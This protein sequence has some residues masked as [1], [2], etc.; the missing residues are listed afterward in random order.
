MQQYHLIHITTGGEYRAPLVASQLFDQAE[1]QATNGGN[2]APKSVHAWTIGAMREYRD[3]AAQKKIQEL[4]TRCPHVSIKM[5]NGVSR[6]NA[7]PVLELMRYH[8][9]KMGNEHRAIYHCRGEDAAIWA[10]KLQQY[11]PNDKIVL[12]VRGHWPSEKLYMNGIEYPEQAT[13]EDKNTYEQL[14]QKLRNTVSQVNGVT[15]VS[16]ALR[17]L[18][19]DEAGA[20]QDTIVVPCCVNKITDDRERNKLR[21]DWGVNE[22]V[23]LVVYSGTTAAYQ[24][25]EDLTIPF[26][27]QLAAANDNIKLAFFSS[28]LDKIA[29]M[30]KGAGIDEQRV[31]LKSFKQNEVGAALTAC[32]IGILIRKPTIVNRVANP[33]K[34][35]EYLAAGLPIIIEQGVGGMDP[36]LYTNG[37]LCGIKL[38]D[39]NALVREELDHVTNWLSMH[40]EQKG[41]SIRAYAASTYLWSAAIHVSR[42]LYQ[43]LL[44]K[45]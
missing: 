36:E 20:S 4:R 16:V 28:E 6:L 14:R 17:Q 21:A 1:C 38:T 26:M 18:L 31:L 12:D 30:V 27:K 10:K 13:G 32:D 3:E 29:A 7:F 45:K 34:I 40:N 42:K 43:Q 15:T 39:K 8:R 41:T 22:N 11:Y 2:G 23:L 9:R 5:I 35:A 19:I 24:H 33:V 44:E 37:L 25:L